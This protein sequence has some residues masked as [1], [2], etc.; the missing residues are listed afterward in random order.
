MEQT[1]VVCRMA[2]IYNCVECVHNTPH[3]PYIIDDKPCTCPGCCIP[4][5]N[6]TEL[7]TY[8]IMV[9]E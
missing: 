5:N 9:E 7:K 6:I 8:C 4:N 3:S 2:R 1:L